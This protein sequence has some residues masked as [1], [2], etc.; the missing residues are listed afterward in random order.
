MKSN[1]R[2]YRRVQLDYIAHIVS[3][4]GQP[5]CDCALVEVSE[6][7]ALLTVL[8]SEMV[9]DQFNLMLSTHSAVRRVC[10]VVRRSDSNVEV[11]Y[12]RASAAGPQKTQLK[13]AAAP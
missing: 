9:P 3:M 5:I 7:D 2:K 10:T 13:P 4:T 8:S 6:D 1:A 11:S 12:R